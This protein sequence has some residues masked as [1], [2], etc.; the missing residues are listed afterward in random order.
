MKETFDSTFLLRLISSESALPFTKPLPHL[1]LLRKRLGRDSLYPHQDGR[2][3]TQ[4]VEVK[5]ENFL[6]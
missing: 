2:V 1:A 4:S 5:Q 3:T 6:Y